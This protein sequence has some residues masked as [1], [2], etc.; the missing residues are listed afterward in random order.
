ME[1]YNEKVRDLLRA[2]AADRSQQMH[3]L[4]VREHPKEGPY[5]ES[6]KWCCRVSFLSFMSS[7]LSD[8]SRHNVGDYEQ[9][10]K[11]MK[12]GNSRRCVSVQ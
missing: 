2:S 12:I 3:K 10:S 11:L 4:K 9:I 5:V 6:K 8:L 7:C 1:I